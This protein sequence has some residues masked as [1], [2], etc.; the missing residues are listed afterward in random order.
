MISL[1]WRELPPPCWRRTSAADRWRRPVLLVAVTRCVTAA[2]MRDCS[3]PVTA[4]GRVYAL[5]IASTAA[6]ILYRPVNSALLPLLCH[7]PSDDFRE[8]R[9]ACSTPSPRWS[10]PPSPQRC[11]RPPASVRF[12]AVAVRPAFRGRHVRPHRRETGG[13]RQQESRSHAV[14]GRGRSIRSPQL[15]PIFSSW[16]FDAHRGALSVFSG[17][18]A[19]TCSTQGE[20]PVGT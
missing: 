2:G 12:V 16:R 10:A 20:P 14:F 13:P 17:W 18:V 11:S 15:R 3:P 4:G 19:V 9:A 8:R 6:A 7:T 5:A 1:R